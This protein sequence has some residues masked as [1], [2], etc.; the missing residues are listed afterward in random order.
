MSDLA[1]PSRHRRQPVRSPSAT[2]SHDSTKSE[3]EPIN[4]SLSRLAHDPA[5]AREG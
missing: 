3:T 4:L 1:R 5:E 2:V